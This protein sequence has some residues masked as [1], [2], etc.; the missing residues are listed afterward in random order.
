[1]LLHNFYLFYRITKICVSHPSPEDRNISNFWYLLFC[2]FENTRQWTSKKPSDPK[3]Y[4]IVFNCSE[5]LLPLIP[6]VDYQ[7]KQFLWYELSSIETSTK[8]TLYVT[9]LWVLSILS[10]SLS[11]YFSAVWLTGIHKELFQ[12]SEDNVIP[13]TF[14]GSRLIPAVF[15]IL[16]QAHQMHFAL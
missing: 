2:V 8:P 7:C 6:A 15:K 9:K 3:Y 11:V 4:K 1:M 5:C 10:T 16:W 12:L 13:L 14:P